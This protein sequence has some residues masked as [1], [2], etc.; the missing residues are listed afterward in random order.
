MG[1]FLKDHAIGIGLA[2]GA[3]TGFLI[4]EGAQND[5]DVTQDAADAM[6]VGAAAGMSVFV[7]GILSLLK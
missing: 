5:P 1:E 3:V 7:A 4:R 2:A 6:A